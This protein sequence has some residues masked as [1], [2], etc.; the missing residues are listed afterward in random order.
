MPTMVIIGDKALNRKLRKLKGPQ[1]KKIVTRAGRTALRSIQFA[2]KINAP[3]DSGALK[4]SIKIRAMPR[5]QSSKKRFG[6]MVQVKVPY[7]QP[8]TYG[9]SRTRQRDPDPY[10]KDAVEHNRTKTLAKYKREL[11]IGIT[12]LAKHG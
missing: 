6:A 2:A 5:D 10:L 12:A 7:V 8:V 1:A 3:V 4:K 9:T 11:R